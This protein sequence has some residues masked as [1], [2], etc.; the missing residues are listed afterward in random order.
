MQ[1]SPGPNRPSRCRRRRRKSVSL[2]GLLSRI[3]QGKRMSGK[4]R[5]CE[6]CRKTL[7]L[8][9]RNFRFHK[10]GI[11]RT[12]KTCLRDQSR[13]YYANHKPRVDKRKLPE[14]EKR[15]RKLIKYYDKIF[16]RLH[17]LGIDPA[18]TKYTA[19]QIDEVLKHGKKAIPKQNNRK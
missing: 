11:S 19:E 18:T 9:K 5:Q 4:T 15:I 8:T 17:R 13:R 1:K 3:M 10:R 6:V 7:A 12:C 14:G 16:R 2:L